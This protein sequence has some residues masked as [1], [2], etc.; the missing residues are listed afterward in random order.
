MASIQK[1][2]EISLRRPVHLTLE[3]ALLVVAFNKVASPEAVERFR[4][5]YGLKDKAAW[6][7]IRALGAKVPILKPFA[8]HL[9]VAES[10]LCYLAVHAD[11]NTLAR[12]VAD[13]LL[14]PMTKRD[15]LKKLLPPRAPK[16]PNEPG[17]PFKMLK[18]L[19]V[20]F[21]TLEIPHP[22]ENDDYLS[23]LRVFALEHGRTVGL[24]HYE[25]VRL[26]LAHHW[27]TV[28]RNTPPT[29]R[30]AARDAEF[31]SVVMDLNREPNIP[32]PPAS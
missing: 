27:A 17:D 20:E 16:P 28:A 23:A 21:H 3:R 11:A 31:D 32:C 30:E 14:T 12:L 2:L 22:N 13:K 7:Q 1:A 18:V 10:S 19:P 25:S 8:R 4:E 6:S 15:E 24:R 26:R 9:P 29:E 5:K